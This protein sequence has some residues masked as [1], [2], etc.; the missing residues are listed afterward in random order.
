MFCCLFLFY[1]DDAALCFVYHVLSSVP[2]F[3]ITCPDEFHLCW[4]PHLCLIISVCIYILCVSPL[5][6]SDRLLSFPAVVVSCS[7]VL[8]F[9]F[10][11]LFIE[12]L[13]SS[14]LVVFWVFCTCSFWF[15]FPSCFVE[16]LAALAFLIWFFG[17]WDFCTFVCCLVQVYS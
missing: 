2:P 9:S 7:L 16:L 15:S 10:V 12:L 5:S 3:V 11:C 6:L 13:V 4:L 17:F 1:F 14:W 8:M